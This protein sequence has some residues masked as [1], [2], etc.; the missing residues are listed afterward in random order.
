M[1]PKTEQTEEG[2]NENSNRK[3]SLLEPMPS[4]SKQRTG[5]RSN[6][7]KIAM[8]QGQDLK[9]VIRNKG[10]F[11]WWRRPAEAGC[12]PR[13]CRV[14]LSRPL[15]PDPS[16]GK[17]DRGPA[18]AGPYNT[19]HTSAALKGSATSTRAQ[20]GR[21]TQFPPRYSRARRAGTMEAWRYA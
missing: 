9:L 15:R 17:P 8:F 12:A 2:L 14:R 13:G 6:R 11:A 10:P 20:F 3:Y 18:E 16:I 1:P 4:H 7:K 5:G 21:E 19:Q